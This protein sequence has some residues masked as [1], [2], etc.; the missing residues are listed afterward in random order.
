MI[1]RID[2]SALSGK[3]PDLIGNWTRIDRLRI[4]DLNGAPTGFP[5]LQNLTN[6]NTLILRNCLIT[7]QIPA[8]LGE[9]TAVKTLF[10]VHGDGSLATLGTLNASAHAATEEGNSGVGELSKWTK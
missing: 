1:S 3:I 9:L 7:G 4:S 5:D 2:G 10:Q 6:M 8:Y